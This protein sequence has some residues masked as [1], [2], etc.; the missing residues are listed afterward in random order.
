VFKALV[1]QQPHLLQPLLP[2]HLLLRQYF[3]LVLPEN[4]LQS[5]GDAA[6]F[7][8]NKLDF[9]MELFV[10]FALIE[11]AGSRAVLLGEL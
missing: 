10:T 3:L 5:G 1:R 2:Q 7:C 11:N 4:V 9:T 6:H 8:I